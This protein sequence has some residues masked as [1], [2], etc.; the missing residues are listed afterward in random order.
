MPYHAIDLSKVRTYPLPQ[1]ANLVAL[2]NLVKPEQDPPPFE[3]LE[4]D[5]VAQA[6]VDSIKK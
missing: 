2:D 5:E 1:R 3:D 6:I 4:L